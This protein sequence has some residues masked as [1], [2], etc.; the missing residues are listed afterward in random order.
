MGPLAGCASVRATGVVLAW[1]LVA[2]SFCSG[3]DAALKK[4]FMEMGEGHPRSL[5]NPREGIMLWEIPDLRIFWRVM[6]S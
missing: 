4:M 2:G 1:L 3:S 5:S 6:V